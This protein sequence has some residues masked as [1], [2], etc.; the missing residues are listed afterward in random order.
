VTVTVTQVHAD[1]RVLFD[2]KVD[3]TPS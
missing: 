3:D 2:L 1:G